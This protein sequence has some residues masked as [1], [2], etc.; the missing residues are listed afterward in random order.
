MRTDIDHPTSPTQSAL[1]A[2]LDGVTRRYGQLTAVDRLSLQ[3]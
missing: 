1:I 2:T 3:L